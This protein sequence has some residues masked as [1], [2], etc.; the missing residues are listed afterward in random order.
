M[1]KGMN[2]MNRTTNQN[3]SR[4]TRIKIDAR[5]VSDASEIIA[6]GWHVS[7]YRGRDR[8]DDFVTITKDN[9]R[10]TVAA[11]EENDTIVIKKF[12]DGNEVDTKT[13]F[14]PGCGLVGTIGIRETENSTAYAF[15]RNEMLQRFM[16]EHDIRRVEFSKTSGSKFD[17]IIQMYENENGSI[18]GFV[19]SGKSEEIDE[20]VDET[21][22]GVTVHK[23]HV[24]DATFIYERSTGTLTLPWVYDLVQL[25]KTF[26]AL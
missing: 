7:I 15:F 6:H 2:I 4:S 8:F 1:Q 14:D 26:S 23:F 3:R 10:F 11:V 22:G 9:V 18:D 13:F 19:T 24:H 12:I 5:G 21:L 17:K 25:R 16:E 20:T